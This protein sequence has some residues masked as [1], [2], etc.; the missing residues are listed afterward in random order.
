[1]DTVEGYARSIAPYTAGF[2]LRPTRVVGDHK[3]SQDKPAEIVQRVIDGLGSTDSPGDTRLA[4][5]MRR[6]H[7]LGAV[8]SRGMPGAL[9]LR[10]VRLAR[11]DRWRTC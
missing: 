1:M 6:V 9:L 4:R 11:A 2:R 3:L 5:E 10:E 7:T 8:V